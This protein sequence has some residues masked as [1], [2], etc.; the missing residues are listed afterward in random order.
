MRLFISIHSL[1]V[2]CTDIKEVKICKN[3]KY[4]KKNFLLSDKLGMCT[5]SKNIDLIDGS[6]SYN[7]ASLYRASDCKDKYYEDSEYYKFIQKIDLFRKLKFS[8]R[9]KKIEY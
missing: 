5:Y 7:F 3:C 9:I 2:P 4:F 1:I 8:S 6:I